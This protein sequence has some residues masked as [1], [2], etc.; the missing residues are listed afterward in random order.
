MTFSV[1]YLSDI[2]ITKNVKGVSLR[3]KNVDDRLH[4]PLFY[5]AY[6]FYL[7]CRI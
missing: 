1:S 6:D 3:L 7:F 2:G 4:A 5:S